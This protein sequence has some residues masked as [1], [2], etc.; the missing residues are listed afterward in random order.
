MANSVDSYVEE[1]KYVLF[2]SNKF[3]HDIQPLTNEKPLEWGYV[4]AK[5]LMNEEAVKGDNAMIKNYS[6]GVCASLLSD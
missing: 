5:K 2:D 4:D 3:S 6:K 1:S